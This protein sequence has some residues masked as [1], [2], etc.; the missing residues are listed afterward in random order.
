MFLENQDKKQKE[1][2]EHMLSAIGSLSRLF[3][4]SNEPYI[5]YRVAENLFCKA[6]GALNLS[7]GDTSAD[8]SKNTLGFGI[9]TFLHKNGRSFEKVAEFNKDHTSF[10]HLG[11]EEKIL[12]ISQLRNE[13]IEA[14][15]RIAGVN[16]II[17]H[18]ITRED[19]KIVV[20]EEPM[21]LVQIERIKNISAD[22]TSIAFSDSVEEYKFSLSKSTLY[23]RFVTQNV[24]LDIPVQIISD[25]FEAVENLFKEENSHQV[26]G[27]IEEEQVF[28][29]LYSKQKGKHVPENSGLNQWNAKGRIRH[30]N[31]VYI[32]IPSWIHKSFPNFF[33]PRDTPFNLHLPNGKTLN[34]KVC[35]DNSKALMTNPNQDLGQWLLRDILNLKEGE[36][37][38]YEKLERIGLDSVIVYKISEGEYGINFV[39]IGSFEDFVTENKVGPQETTD[40]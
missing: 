23:K 34:A 29:P 36:L 20:Y 17:Y 26:V 21:H 16:D 3:S 19:G 22:D 40:E 24:L 10:S 13:R 9:K 15:K 2:Y 25:P 18:C 6:F 32:P 8:A 38:T 27:K 1:Y 30:P 4:E 12:K 39:K 14:T 7:R 5:A 35:Q 11:P 37:L 28:L 31:E 33:P